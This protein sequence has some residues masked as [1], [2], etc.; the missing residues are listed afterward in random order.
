MDPAFWLRYQ[1]LNAT[2]KDFT[3]QATALLFL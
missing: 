2:L 3:C 1:D